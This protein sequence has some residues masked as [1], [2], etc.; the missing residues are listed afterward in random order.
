MFDNYRLKKQLQREQLEYEISQYKAANSIM[1]GIE[2][3][4]A[5]P[6]PDEH[7]WLQLGESGDG[8][9]T[10]ALS[11]EDHYEML[12]QAWKMFKTNLF[13]R[14][15]V[16]NLGKF[17]LGKGPI[18]K[19]V[20]DNQLI[21]DKWKEFTYLNKWSLREKEIVRR[22]FRDGEVFL[23]KFID[24]QTGDTKLR[25]LRAQMIRNP[26]NDK[27]VNK[28]EDVSFGIGTNN[29]DV[30]EPLTYYYCK[31][32]DSTL[33]EKIPA[34][35]VIHIK[36]LT[37]SDMKRGMSFLLIA[38]RMLTKYDSWMEDRISLNQA[39]S[40]IALV[41]KVEGTGSAVESIRDAYRAEHKDA[42]KHKQKAFQRGTV[43][44]ASKGISYE[45]LSPNIQASDVKDDGRN[46]LLAI[47]AGC[48]FPEMMLTSDYSNANYSSSMVAQ[49]PFVREIEDWQDFF[50]HY[51]KNEI[52]IPVMKAYQEY[53]DKKI[54]DKEDLDCT[55]EWPPLI[56]ADIYKNNQAREIQHRNKIISKK[57][58][59]EREGLDSDEEERN[60]EDEQGKD[61]YSNP[62][63][64]PVSPVNQYSQF[65]DSED[66]SM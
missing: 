3:R 55:I 30:E 16:R 36:I 63:N 22:V 58:W 32:N 10:A 42:D 61:I 43:L 2:A 20:S 25:F 28:A 18:V 9:Y 6:D 15:I 65:G 48:G 26:K 31:M 54:P 44:T 64:M 56:L 21:K 59:Q 46:M 51:Y 4:Y 47:A 53:G 38:M 29:D 8:K 40:A 66:E 52:F 17:I 60:M 1:S 45:M 27:D 13:A 39:R 37:D 50:T 23:R 12:D 57:T 35:E 7:L 49:N 62:F 34:S 19:P 24:Q 5:R 33:I 41:R 11:E 14:A